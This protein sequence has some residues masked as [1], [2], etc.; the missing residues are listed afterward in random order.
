MCKGIPGSGKSYW[1]AEYQV[2]HPE[3]IIVT[4][5]DIREQFGCIGGGWS[6]EKES[7][8]IDEMERRIIDGLREG[9]TVISADTNLKIY[10]ERKMRHLAMICRANF[11]IKTFDTSL[12]ECIKR[13]SERV[14]NRKVGEHNIRKY[15]QTLMENNKRCGQN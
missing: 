2:M 3:T 4:R 7:Y 6:P 5:D 8:V 11:V 13:D 1:A 9:K 14:G 12:D 15:Y 10:H